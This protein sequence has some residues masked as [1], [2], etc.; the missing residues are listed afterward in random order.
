MYKHFHKVILLLAMASVTL[1][2]FS[3]AR[4]ERKMIE[5]YD[6]Y[7]S[8][9]V[10]FFDGDGNNIFLDQLEGTNILLVFWATWCGGCVDEI[11]T[12]DNL[13]YDFRKLPFKVIAVSQDYQGI[14]IVKKHFTD[15]EIRHI[16]PF[17]DPGNKLF[18]EL[19]VVNLP[20]AFFIN[21]EGKNKIVFRGVIKW[22]DN[23][24]REM[25]LTEMGENLELPKNTYKPISLN[26]KVMYNSS[27]E[28]ENTEETKSEENSETKIEE[29]KEDENKAK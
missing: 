2:S 8:N 24:I 13:Q 22:Q 18:R 10:P 15:H 19:S 27:K 17:H 11:P 25:F 14:E 6:R 20:T 28:I 9:D 21:A 4:A 5:K 1:F 23:E 7:L 3:Q 29:R 26:R 12:L 16:E